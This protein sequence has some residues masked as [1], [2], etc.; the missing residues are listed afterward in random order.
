MHHFCVT[1][2][3]ERRSRSKR[4][5]GLTEGTSNN[6]VEKSVSCI[7]IVRPK[8]SAENLQ[9]RIRVSPREPK[10]TQSTVTW[11]RGQSTHLSAMQHAHQM[12]FRMSISFCVNSCR[13][14]CVHFS[15]FRFRPRSS[16]YQA[17]RATMSLPISDPQI[18][19][20]TKRVLTI[21]IAIPTTTNVNTSAPRPARPPL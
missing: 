21:R 7:A 11:E 3:K 14:S 8:N 6:G 13:P 19:R 4:R 17:P 20:S 18:T 16:A 2:G 15:G 9:A 10:C 5:C 12:R 1:R